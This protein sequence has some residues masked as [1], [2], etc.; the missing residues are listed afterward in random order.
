M[1]S[2][3]P[4]IL[5][6]MSDQH[7]WDV[8][9][10]AG[11][12]VVRTPV[13]DELARTGVTFDNAYTPSPVCVPARQC[14]TAGQLPSTC[15]CKNFGDD[16][17]SQTRTFARVF[18]EHAYATVVCGKLH[19]DGLDQNQGWRLRIGWDNPIHPKFIPGYKKEEE[20][21]GSS[22]WWPWDKEIARA[23][24]GR[25]P[26]AVCDEMAIWGAQE[27]LTE[28]FSSPHY[29]HPNP[30]P[31][32]LKVSLRLPHYPFLTTENRFN[33]YLNRV[34]CYS[35]PELFP[36]PVLSRDPIRLG[37]E[38]TERELRRATAAYYG[39]VETIDTMYGQVLD[40]LRAVGQNPDDWLII[41]TSDHGEMLGD[42]GVWMKYKF[43]EGSVRVPLIIRWPQHFLGGRRVQGNV[44]LCDLYA[45]L[46]DCADLE[47]PPGLD[48]RSLRPLLTGAQS[49]FPGDESISQIGSHLMIKRGALK[50]QHYGEDGAEVLFD[51]AQDAGETRNFIAAPD[52]ETQVAAFRARAREL[53]QA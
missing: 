37:Q 31:L 41:Y 23:G 12:S 43:F 40:Q 9:G 29:D 22:S 50:Y 14:L 34:P 1:K 20:A 5:F 32:L 48:S 6:L 51:L 19:H 21:S 25:S 16:L 18:S 33:Y 8:A 17:P 30:N 13:L 27:Y 28:H 4:N 49:Q 3:R 36:H 52:Y 2:P 44:N 53:L 39:M 11:N 26:H 45:T 38:T 42:H 46:C 35:D 47:I 10:F 7:R 15:G 24:I